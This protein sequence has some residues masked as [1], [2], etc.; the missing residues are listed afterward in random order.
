MKD[1]GEAQKHSH[2]DVPLMVPPAARTR[3]TT[4]ASMGDTGYS[5]W[6]ERIEAGAPS[7]VGRPPTQMLSLI[8]TVRP[9]RRWLLGAAAERLRWWLQAL[10]EF[11]VAVGTQYSRGCTVGSGCNCDGI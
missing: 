5:F 11:C 9:C 1:V 7:I 8:A 4:V 10:Y 2:V 3:E 6:S